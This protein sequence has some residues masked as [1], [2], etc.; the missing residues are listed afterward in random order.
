[1][2][3]DPDEIHFDCPK[4]KRPMT[5][6]KALL[7]E[8]INCPDCGEAFNPTPRKPEPVAK[9]SGWKIEVAPR[10]IAES[11][12]PTFKRD[13]LALVFQCVT[14]IA[15]IAC[16]VLIYKATHP[17]SLPRW[18]YAAFE[19]NN[20]RYDSQNHPNQIL[21]TKIKIAKKSQ[22]DYEVLDTPITKIEDLLKEIGCYGWELVCFDG[23]H[24]IVKRLD[25]VH[26]SD[27]WTNGNFYLLS[28]EWFDP[29]A[30]MQKLQNEA[31]RPA[32][33]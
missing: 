23:K 19:W 9:P 3:N 2:K 25:I 6:D 5:G 31:P 7:G 22:Y 24:Y 30:D 29:K 17:A 28:D 1:M 32:P 4:C 12:A 11:S 13:W 27:Y 8:L 15:A 16:A 18:E 26:R 14:A 20:E 10:A 33:Q 21:V